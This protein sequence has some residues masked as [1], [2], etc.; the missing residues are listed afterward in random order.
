[1]IKLV[2]DAIEQHISKQA[3][4]QPEPVAWQWLNTAHFRK[5]LPKDAEKNAWNPLYTT[6][7]KREPLTDE[8]ILEVA[9]NHYNPHQRAEISFA[10]A[11]EQAHGIGE[12]N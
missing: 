2:A 9:R 3:L 12:K 10:R 1:V 8:Q 7:P 6:P 4:E 5:K 11:I